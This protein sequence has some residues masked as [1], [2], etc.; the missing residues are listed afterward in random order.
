M[1]KW[2]QSLSDTGMNGLIIVL[3]IIV[4]SLWLLLIGTGGMMGFLSLILLVIVT[5]AFTIFLK[6]I[7]GASVFEDFAL[8]LSDIEKQTLNEMKDT[9]SGKEM[10]KAL[11]DMQKSINTTIE[12]QRNVQQG[13]ADSTKILKIRNM[14]NPINNT[15]LIQDVEN[16][17]YLLGSRKG[18]VDKTINKLKSYGVSDK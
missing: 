13:V 18:F 3:N 8:F 9:G 14:L 1:K 10:A 4:Y 11:K 6:N 7:S 17:L 5:A 2:L 12:S 16:A 15:I